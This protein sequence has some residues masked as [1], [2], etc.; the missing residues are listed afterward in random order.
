MATLPTHKLGLN[1]LES[2]TITIFIDNHDTIDLTKDNKHHQRTKHIDVM[3]HFI[4]EHVKN[5]TFTIV[6]C[7][8]TEMLA[9]GFTNLLLHVAFKEM[10]DGLRL[11]DNTITLG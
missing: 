7:P 1:Y 3:H 10:V 2:Q 8:G 5:G 9:E 4:C 11:I 6:H